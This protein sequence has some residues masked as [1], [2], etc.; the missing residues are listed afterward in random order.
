LIPIKLTS[1]ARNSYHKKTE[2]YLVEETEVITYRR[3]KAK[4]KRQEELAPLMEEFLTGV[5]SRLFSKDLS[6]VD[7]LL[8]TLSI[9]RR[10]SRRSWKMADWSISFTVTCPN[11][12][13]K[14][15]VHACFEGRLI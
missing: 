8:P 5:V 15:D 10:P 14:Q 13:R 4:G 2:T 3:K 12:E 9:M 6:L 1:L 11:A 7:L